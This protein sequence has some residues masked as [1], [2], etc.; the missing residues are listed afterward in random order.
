MKISRFKIGILL[1]LTMFLVIGAYVAAAFYIKNIGL[2]LKASKVF[3]YSQ[4]VEYFLQNDSRWANQK[5]GNSD[6]TLA[7]QG[8]TIT[9]VAMVLH[10]LGNEINPALLNKKL[11]QNNAYTGNGDLLWYELEEIFPVKYK[12]KRV[13]SAGTLERDL[14]NGVLPLVR[15]KYGEKGLEHWVLI[16]GADGSDFLL[17]DPLNKNKTLTRLSEYGRV[18]AYRAIVPKTK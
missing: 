15:V 3:D 7:E 18:Y 11:I 5:L 13:F 9:D 6:R 4:S 1:L 12:F 10:Y 17:M 8:C 16:V 2:E 14:E